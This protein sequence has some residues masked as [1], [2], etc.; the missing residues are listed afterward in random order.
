VI[1]YTCKARTDADYSTI[2]I[3]DGKL[4]NP[5]RLTPPNRSLY[6]LKKTLQNCVSGYGLIVVGDKQQGKMMR[7]LFPRIREFVWLWSRFP[8][9]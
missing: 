8:R 1:G 2:T 4:P 3:I 5:D 9:C 6:A 7:Y